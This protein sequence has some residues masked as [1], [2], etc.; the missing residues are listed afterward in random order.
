MARHLLTDEEYEELK[1]AEITNFFYTLV[2]GA[3]L[4]EII[5]WVF[6][7]YIMWW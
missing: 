1:N 6:A 5:K 7:N 2:G 4:W 3:V